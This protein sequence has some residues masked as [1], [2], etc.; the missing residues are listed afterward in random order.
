MLTRLIIIIALV[1]AVYY[2]LRWFLNTPPAQVAKVLR[3]GLLYGGIGLLVLLVL[4]GRLHWLFA[5]LGALVPLVQRGLALAR[6]VPLV[7]R[8]LGM[9]QGGGGGGPGAGGGR[10]STIATRFL[11]M[12]L[13]HDSGVMDG[14]VL[15]GPY[16]GRELSA[17]DLEA[18][19]A[20]YRQCR[21]ADDQSTAVLEA[22]LDRTHGDAWRQGA[23]ADD[24]AGGNP[25]HGGGTMTRDE[26]AA[27]LGVP[28]D[29]DTATVRAAHRRLMQK[30]HPDRGGSDYLAAKVNQA[31]DLMLGD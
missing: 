9:A 5:A 27:V 29:A 4:S 26:A 14:V 28:P 12:T 3:Q 8:V 10:T 30:L 15:E 19:Q 6:V 13:D 16:Q 20:L 11:R 22:Y 2:G 23:G 1:A 24:A 31:K 17:M 7:R 25:G 18:L 21:A